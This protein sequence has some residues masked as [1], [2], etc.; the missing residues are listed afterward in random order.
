MSSSI[1]TEAQLRGITRLCHFT[2]SRNLGHIASSSDG[3][4]SSS[5]LRSDQS[6][7]F[8][9]TDTKRIDGYTGHISC[10]IEYPNAWYLSKAEALEPLFK[11]WVVLFVAPHY[12]WHPATH[13]CPR[14]AAANSGGQVVGSLSGFQSLFAQS[15]AG[16]YG[17]T[18]TRGTKHLTCSPTDDQAEVLVGT[19]I[20]SSDILGVA[21]RDV[22]QA[23]NEIVRLRLAG[24]PGNPFQFIIAPTLFNKY[25]LSCSIRAGKRPVELI[26]QGKP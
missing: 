1:K 18:N 24:I 3:V 26:Y 22:V 14:N 21:V 13:Y 2:P 23:K 20:T 8:T 7:C 17:K 12:I 16:A 25:E 9:A 19:N 10:S 15:I 5:A 4:R 6:A 11:D